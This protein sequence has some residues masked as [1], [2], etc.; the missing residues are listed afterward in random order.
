MFYKI[1]SK[2]LSLTSVKTYLYFWKKSDGLN[3]TVQF[4]FISRIREVISN[5]NANNQSNSK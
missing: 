5:P 1:F 3:N 2:K 4:S